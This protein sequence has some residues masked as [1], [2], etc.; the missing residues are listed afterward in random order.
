MNASWVIDCPGR[1]RIAVKY[2]GALWLH[3]FPVHYLTYQSPR[4]LLFQLV[5]LLFR[6]KIKLSLNSKQII[7]YLLR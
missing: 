2:Y 6:M 4:D 1:A 7:K 3:V 5:H